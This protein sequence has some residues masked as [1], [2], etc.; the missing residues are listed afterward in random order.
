MNCFSKK[1]ILYTWNNILS[2]C[3]FAYDT[4]DICM[5]ES[6]Y[7]LLLDIKIKS[8]ELYGNKYSE[9]LHIPRKITKKLASLH[10]KLYL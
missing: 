3:Q 9:Q 5:L 8:K 4:N 2:I 7:F 6:S 10:I 1:N